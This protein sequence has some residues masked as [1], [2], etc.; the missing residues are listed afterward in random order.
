M[1]GLHE[2]G[3]NCLKYLKREW[4][5]RGRETKILKREGEGAC[6]IKECLKKRGAG[7][8]LQTTYVG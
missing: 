3:G 4:N 6:W 5:R 7:T 1:R 8:L 2:D